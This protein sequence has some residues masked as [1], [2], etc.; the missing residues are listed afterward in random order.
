MKSDVLALPYGAGSGFVS[1]KTRVPGWVFCARIADHAQPW[2]R[3]VAAAPDWTPFIREETGKPWIID[4]TLSS[5]VAADP[6]GRDT[7]ANIPSGAAEGVFDAWAHAHEHIYTTWTRL[8]DV[9]NLQPDIPLA[10]REA[11]ELVANHGSYLGIEKQQGLLERL[12]AR[13]DKRI[14]DR[15]REIVRSE[16]AATAQINEL[17]MFVA[18]AGLE[19][20][21]PA[22]PLPVIERDEVR[23]VC[24]T[25]V[26]PLRR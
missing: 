5:L 6:G 16:G 1:E 7:E 3:F 17:A 2:F 11:A 4:D 25:A 23:L 9:A 21:E 13:W 19:P 20:P 15:V 24:W 14:V 12:N 10:L 26:T 22:E 18:D 8:S